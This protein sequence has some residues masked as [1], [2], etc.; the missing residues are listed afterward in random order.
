M[1]S[2][3]SPAFWMQ[4]NLSIVQKAPSFISQAPHRWVW[5]F[6]RAEFRQK[7]LLQDDSKAEWAVKVPF[8]MLSISSKKGI[9]MIKVTDLVNCWE[10]PKLR[11]CILSRP[12]SM[13]CS[14]F[15]IKI[16]SGLLFEISW[17]LGCFCFCFLI[18][19]L[20]VENSN[21]WRLNRKQFNRWSNFYSEFTFIKLFW[22][23]YSGI[24]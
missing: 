6:S 24:S 20:V 13:Y 4:R 3:G 18:E 8:C 1:G 14:E 5:S 15:N 12:A 17:G 10:Y 2:N 22:S 23:E 7:S 9:Y 21:W 16:V 11:T 19:C